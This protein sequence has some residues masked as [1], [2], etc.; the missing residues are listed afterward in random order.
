MP[1]DDTHAAFRMTSG[2]QKRRHERY[3]HGPE[4][5][6][7]RGANGRVCAPERRTTGVH[8][9]HP[10]NEHHGR[11]L[12]TE[13]V[14]RLNEVELSGRTMILI[15]PPFAACAATRPR[16]R[17]PEFTAGL[18]LGRRELCLIGFATEAAG[19]SVFTQVT[20]RLLRAGD[21]RIVRGSIPRHPP[22]GHVAVPRGVP[23]GRRGCEL[24]HSRNAGR[25]FG[26]LP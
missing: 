2:A 4:S 12:Q 26:A 21:Y 9:L 3:T 11:P 7:V 23:A 6:S 14:E 20:H 19:E 16:V 10:Q 1:R 22:A 24:P 25:V 17:T 8:I 18:A 13:E 5:P 15:F